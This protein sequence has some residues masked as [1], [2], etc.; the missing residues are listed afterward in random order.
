MSNN[1]VGVKMN[2]ILTTINQTQNLFK[3]NQQST[4]NKNKK[5]PI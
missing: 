5:L 4:N 2:K 1:L 3:I